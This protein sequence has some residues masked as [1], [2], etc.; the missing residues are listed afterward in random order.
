MRAE[1][2]ALW[3][4]WVWLALPECER[5]PAVIC[6]LLPSHETFPQSAAFIQRP[7]CC[8]FTFIQAS[9]D[10]SSLETSPPS[11]SLMCVFITCICIHILYVCESICMT[12]G[13]KYV[14]VW[15]YACAW[16]G[17]G[18]AYAC[19]GQNFMSGTISHCSSPLFMEAGSL[20]NQTPELAD[21]SGL[22]SQLSLESP[23]SAL[24]LCYH[25]QGVFECISGDLNSGP[26]ACTE[27]TLTI[28]ISPKL[29][30]RLLMQ[31]TIYLSSLGLSVT[32]AFT[33]VITLLLLLH[34]K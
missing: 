25:T 17:A 7:H 8:L 13:C 15:G 5:F 2:E 18:I 22:S 19:G 11:P 12:G 14:F 9:V 30:W 4:V 32:V 10:P 28:R 23:I 16:W 1:V 31:T 29:Q 3:I 6:S 33:T 34:N 27:N 21:M 24:R 26:L 20:Y